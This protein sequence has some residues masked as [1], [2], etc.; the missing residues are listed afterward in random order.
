MLARVMAT[1]QGLTAGSGVMSPVLDPLLALN[2]AE[3]FGLAFRL[4]SDDAD[5]LGDPVRVLPLAAGEIAQF[6]YQVHR[7]SR[8][9]EEGRRHIGDTGR[10]GRR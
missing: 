1:K 9:I 2:E 4:L 7:P 10:R 6:E 3:E 5:A 8:P